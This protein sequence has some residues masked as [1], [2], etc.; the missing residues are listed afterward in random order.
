MVS[1]STA[2]SPITNVVIMFMENHTYDNLASDVAGGDG[3]LSLAL[4]AD[5]PHDAPHNHAAWM[6]RATGAVRQRYTRAQVPFTVSLMDRYSVCDRY[7]SDVTANSFPNH[8]FAIGAD[9]E[10]AITNPAH[11]TKPFL[12]HPGVPVRLAASGHSWGNYGHG[13]AFGYYTDPAMRTNSHPVTQIITDARDGHLPDVC[14]VY[15]PGGKDFH[16]GSSAMSASDTWL[17]ATIHAITSGKRADGQPLWDHLA[18]F[19]TFDDW[20]G[21]SDHVSPPVVETMPSGDPYRYGS[22][23]PCI[24]VS[25]YAKA[26]HVSHDR[27]SHT[28]LVAYIERLYQ[29]P[30]S[31]NPAAAARTTSTTEHALA[32]CF[33]TAPYTLNPAP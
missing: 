18:L 31:T 22:R 30:T 23:V 10:G 1:G 19:V 7:Y 2:L 28:S 17:Q 11:G 25:P 15:G 5:H 9:A 4:A 8:A 20:G 14:W 16:P 27:S 24:V 13:F 29:L 6:R 26:S 3:D 33:Q 12:T 21:W 32:D